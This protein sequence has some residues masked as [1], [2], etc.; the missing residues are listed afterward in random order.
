MDGERERERHIVGTLSI[1]NTVFH[2]QRR[3]RQTDRHK[4]ATLSIPNTV[5]H[6]LL[7]DKLA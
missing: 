5:F 6:R 4:V 1:P 2:R 3:E 7:D